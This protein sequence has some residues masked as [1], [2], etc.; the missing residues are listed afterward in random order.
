MPA[1]RRA[2]LPAISRPLAGASLALV[3]AS[4]LRAAARLQRDGTCRPDLAQLVRTA[5]RLVDPGECLA[6]VVGDGISAGDGA[7]ADLDL[8]R[9]VAARGLG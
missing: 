4:V 8:N 3:L 9:V 5:G 2:R 7:G 6:E 1:V